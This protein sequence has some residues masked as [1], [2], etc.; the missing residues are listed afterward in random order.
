M[1][2]KTHHSLGSYKWSEFGAVEQHAKKK[3]LRYETHAGPIKDSQLADG[4]KLSVAEGMI[5]VVLITSDI[6]AVH[7][8][9]DDFE[10]PKQ[11]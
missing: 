4:T 9:W 5:A 3:G 10:I 8:F 1:S 6:D 7:H 11:T 2:E